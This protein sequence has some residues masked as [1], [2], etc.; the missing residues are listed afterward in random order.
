MN[1]LFYW[2]Q[3]TGDFINTKSM[4]IFFNIFKTMKLVKIQL[5][6]ISRKMVSVPK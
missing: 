5:A 2:V 6:E 1:M 3:F 4:M